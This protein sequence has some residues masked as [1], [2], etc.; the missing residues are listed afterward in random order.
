M[1]LHT[2]LNMVTILFKIMTCMKFPIV[3]LF[4]GLQLRL[5]GGLSNEL[6]LQLQFPVFV[7]KCSYMK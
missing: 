7:A 1:E 3:K 4:R 5:S 2:P 6:A